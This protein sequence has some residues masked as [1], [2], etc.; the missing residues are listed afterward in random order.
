VGA[1]ERAGTATGVSGC[2]ER[3]VVDVKDYIVGRAIASEQ[4]AGQ[5]EAQPVLLAAVTGPPYC[6]VLSAINFG[7]AA[8]L[9][10]APRIG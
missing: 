5:D 10:V 3:V 8:D 4:P 1:P 2:G 6:R 9:F 7:Q